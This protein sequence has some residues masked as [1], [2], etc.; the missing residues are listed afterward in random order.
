MACNDDAWAMTVCSRCSTSSLLL[1]A[2]LEGAVLGDG[3]NRAE[4]GPA[5]GI[6]RQQHQG[7]LVEQQLTPGYD[8]HAQLL[9][10]VMGPHHAGE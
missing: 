1:H 7:A 5:P 6:H 3:Q 9:A 4:V 8:P 10:P 2:P